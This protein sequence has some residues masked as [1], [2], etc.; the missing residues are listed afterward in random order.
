[1]R[2]GWLLVL[3]LAVACKADNGKDPPPPGASP[4]AGEPV[5]RLVPDI[6]GAKLLQT[7]SPDDRQ[8]HVRWCI[9]EVDAASRVTRALSAAGWSDVATRGS[10]DRI[11]LAASKPGVRFSAAIGGNDDACAGTLVTAT[12]VRLDPAAR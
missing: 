7:R 8:T 9:D 1:M 3:L 2:A 12:I 5:V 6:L 11:A 10:G 4:P